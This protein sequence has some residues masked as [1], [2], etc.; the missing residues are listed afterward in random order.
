MALTFGGGISLFD[1]KNTYKKPFKV[2]PSDGVLSYFAPSEFTPCVYKGD[3]VKI[4]TPLMKNSDSFNVYSTVSGRVLSVENGCVSVEND[5]LDTTAHLFEP[6]TSDANSITRE[7]FIEYIKL[8]GIVGA[9]SGTPVY[10]KLEKGFGKIKRLVVSF[11]ET[12]PYSGHTRTFAHCFSSDII[13]G[14]KLVMFM[15]GIEKCVLAFSKKNKELA[16]EYENADFTN[17]TVTNAF[18]SDK[19]PQGV[20]RLLVASIYDAEIPLTQECYER[21]YLVLSA[22]TVYNIYN[23]L[24]NGSCV[25]YKALSFA[26]DGARAMGNVF[27]LIGTSFQNVASVYGTRPN[28]KLVSGGL[29]G[30][31]IERG[32][33]VRPNSNMILATRYFEKHP[34]ECI[35][36]GKCVNAC[37][38]RIVPIELYENFVSGEHN[39]NVENGLYNCIECGC[40]SYVCPSFIDLRGAIIFDK[41]RDVEKPDTDLP[42]KQI[43]SEIKTNVDTNTKLLNIDALPNDNSKNTSFN[44]FNFEDYIAENTDGKEGTDDKES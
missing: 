24:K 40:C 41:N 18:V 25:R 10:S 12:E 19:H 21:G 38:M 37:P 31:K 42:P 3:F 26:G 16:F 34:Q 28:A 20:G 11:V 7:T 27:A 1:Y 32:A 33:F 5:G 43:E 39:K 15:M 35:K 6:V 14:I 8:A 9:Y 29:I 23:C 2:A 36:C 13:L 22:E 30:G 4:N 44:S 17:G